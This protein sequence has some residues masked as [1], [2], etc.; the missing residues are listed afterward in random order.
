MWTLS[1]TSK[2]QVWKLVRGHWD[3]RQGLLFIE[4][5]SEGRLPLHWSFPRAPQILLRICLGFW[6]W[7][8]QIFSI[9]RS[10]VWP[11]IY[12]FF[13]YLYQ[14]S[15]AASAVQLSRFV[16]IYLSLVSSVWEPVQ[17]ITWLEVVLYTIDGFVQACSERIVK[18]SSA[19]GSLLELSSN[20]PV[21]KVHVKSAT[22][23]AGQN[24]SLSPYVGLFTRVFWLGI[25]FQR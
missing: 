24:I 17:V 4:I 18:L 15:Q 6:L 2:V 8:V 10:S 3:F 13:F 19:L 21:C 16:L 12:S 1:S 5:W 23:V 20:H 25:S 22:S 7:E 11:S 14:D 9:L